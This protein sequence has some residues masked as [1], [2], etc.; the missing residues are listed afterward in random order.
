MK[1]ILLLTSS[2][3]LAA[4][5][6]SSKY[7]L[8]T[9]KPYTPVEI[10]EA[11]EISKEVAFSS[12]TKL[13]KSLKYYDTAYP[14]SKGDFVFRG[15]TINFVY[16]ATEERTTQNIYSIEYKNIDNIEI[17][18]QELNNDLDNQIDTL[19]IHKQTDDYG[20]VLFAH[21]IDPDLRNSYT[22]ACTEKNHAFEAGINSVVYRRFAMERICDY[23]NRFADYDK[24]IEFI[25]DDNYKHTIKYAT[26]G[27]GSVI[28]ET[29]ST[30][31]SS[32]TINGF[33][34]SKVEFKMEYFRNFLVGY[35]FEV[36]SD[37]NVIKHETLSLIYERPTI[38]LPD[39]W[40]GH[41]KTAED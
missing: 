16:N 20:N 9:I 7:S 10:P 5:D 35:E 28:L 27:E 36:S 39:Y 24:F 25:E 8:E 11:H 17:S 13:I 1:K 33:N 19:I 34:V 6:P 38:E 18:F 21:K 2:L 41:I 31:N 37:S 40:K 23:Y 30:P 29:T 15:E 14:S 4:C 22:I 26:R 32:T 3:L 12:I